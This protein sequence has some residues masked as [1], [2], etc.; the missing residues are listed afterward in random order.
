MPGATAFQPHWEEFFFPPPNPLTGLI[1]LPCSAAGPACP[2]RRASWHRSHLPTVCGGTFLWLL[3][4]SGAILSAHAPQGSTFV[5]WLRS[6][7]LSCNHQSRVVKAP[8]ARWQSWE[9]IWKEMH[10][11]SNGFRFPSENETDKCHLGKLPTHWREQNREHHL[12]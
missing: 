4:R 2:P 10:G 6:G 5:V 1:P 9:M 12:L 3:Q 11:L 7:A 8:A